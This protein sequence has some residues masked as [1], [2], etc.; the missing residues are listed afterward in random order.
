MKDLHVASFNRDD[1]VVCSAPT[2]SQIDIQCAIS[3]TLWVLSL[4]SPHVADCV[5]VDVNGV[6]TLTRSGR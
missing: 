5:E 1:Q 2:L 3:H 4:P 6:L